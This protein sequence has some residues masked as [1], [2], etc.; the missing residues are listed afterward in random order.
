MAQAPA[1]E[2]RRRVL[3][4]HGEQKFLNECSA[5]LRKLGYEVLTAREGFEALVVLRGAVPEVLIAELELPRMS[6]FELLAVVRSR[7][8]Q[9][10]VIATSAAYTTHSLPVETTADAFVSEGPNM[11]F[12]LMEAVHGAISDSPLR[13]SKPKSQSPSV[14]IPRSSTGYIILTCPECLRS[15]S[16]M[17]PRAEADTTNEICVSCGTRVRF[18]MSAAATVR[19]PGRTDSN[20]ASHDRIRRSEA[21]ISA[22]KQARAAG[23]AMSGKKKR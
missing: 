5:E 17:Q 10:A 16:V 22:S 18:S 7:F 1:G 13:G 3:L 2:F 20:L 21:A 23:K 8:P 6:G 15:F 14:W 19:P 12:E 4:V 11:I 9:I